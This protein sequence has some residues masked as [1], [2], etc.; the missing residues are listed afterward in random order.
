MGSRNGGTAHRSASIGGLQVSA[1]DSISDCADAVLGLV[2]RPGGGFVAAINPEKV[3]SYRVDPEVR[4]ILDQTTLRYP[5]GAGVMLAMRSK[6]VSTVRVPGADLWLEVLRRGAS[7][8]TKVALIGGRPSVLA[9]AVDKLNADFPDI[10]I[11][12]AR[13]GYADAADCQLLGT[14][15]VRLR[16][17]VVF[18]AMGSPRQEILIAECRK[19][20]PAGVYLG[21][22]GSLDVY[23]GVKRRAPKPMRM[24]G[25]EWLYRLIAEPSR[26]GRQSR[27]LG[28]VGLL[29]ARR[30]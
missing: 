28:F 23:T 4:N 10:G 22:G 8:G 16:P 17:Q 15:L 19:V 24:V 30:L 2:G 14:E 11:V 25:A 20:Y 6:G 18:V 12:M 29:L 1:F 3:M 26:A 5:D 13:N 7:T 9:Q 21:L 27:L